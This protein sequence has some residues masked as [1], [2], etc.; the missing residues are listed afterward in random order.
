MTQEFV[1]DVSV[2]LA[3][4]TQIRKTFF[5]K[6]YM[7]MYVCTHMCICK[8]YYISVYMY[9]CVYFSGKICESRCVY[10]NILMV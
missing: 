6:K 8:V 9:V 5:R 7:Q 1:T 10:I 4:N 2:I 3:P